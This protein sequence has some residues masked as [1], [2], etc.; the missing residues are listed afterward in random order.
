MAPVFETASPATYHALETSFW[1]RSRCEPAL[2]AL[3]A[4]MADGQATIFTVD[5]P[6][7]LSFG[8]ALHSVFA[9]AGSPCGSAKHRLTVPCTWSH[10][11]GFS[12]PSM[13]GQLVAR[14]FGPFANVHVRALYA[15]D[16]DV[17]GRIFHEAIGE[18]VAHKTFDALVGAIRLVL[19]S[20][21][22]QKMVGKR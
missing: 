6:S 22:T 3:I 10:Q 2:N 13:T 4:A 14:R 5:M 20:H 9:L 8:P 16:T 18:R 12:L 7:T 19:S 21:E 11:R 17:A 1:L 15:H